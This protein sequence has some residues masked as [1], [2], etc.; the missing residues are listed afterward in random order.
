MVIYP[1]D[2][3][4]H[5]HSIHMTY[6][7]IRLIYISMTYLVMIH[8]HIDCNRHITRHT[9]IEKWISISSYIDKHIYKKYIHMHIY[10]YIYTHT[11]TFDGWTPRRHPGIHRQ[12]PSCSRK[13]LLDCPRLRSEFQW[14]PT[15]AMTN[16]LLQENHKENQRKMV[17]L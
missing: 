1:F 12:K 16:S 10:I 6:M 17:P 7:S 14:I 2:I 11:H 8:A 3:H 5:K 9:L 4:M 13:P 15:L